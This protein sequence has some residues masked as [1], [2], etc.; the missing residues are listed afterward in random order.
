VKTSGKIGMHILTPWRQEGGSDTARAWAIEI[1]QRLAAELPDTATVEQRKNRRQKKVYVDVLHNARGHH[2]VP[3]YVLRPVPQATV[4][5]PLDWVELTPELD[6]QQYNF[7]TIFQR[8]AEQNDDPMVP[9]I[10][11]RRVA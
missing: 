1:A 8:L 2:G 3:P 9:F 4:S 10:R 5:T 11:C 7:K 6:P